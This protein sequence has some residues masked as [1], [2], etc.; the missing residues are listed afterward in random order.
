VRR[1]VVECVLRRKPITVTVADLLEE[2]GP[3]LVEDERRRIGSLV[4]R[5][6][7]QA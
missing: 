7:A 5:I 1:K 2:N 6:P 3:L 4:R